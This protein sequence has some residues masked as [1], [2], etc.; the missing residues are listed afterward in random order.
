MGSVDEM[1]ELVEFS[2]RIRYNNN[3]QKA[4]YEI[5][6]KLPREQG[7]RNMADRAYQQVIDYLKQ[8]IIDKKYQLWDKLPSERELSE[9]LGVSRNSVREALKVLEIMGVVESH[10]GAGNYVADGFEKNLVETMSMMYALNKIDD[11]QVSDYRQALESRAYML[12]ME[13]I[14]DKDIAQMKHCIQMIQESQKD[15]EKAYWDKMFHYTMVRASG[16][17]MLIKNIEALN[18]I[19]DVFILNMRSSISRTEDGARLLQDAHCQMVEA[20][21]EKDMEKGMKAMDAHFL[22]IKNSL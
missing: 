12:A 15:E 19:I 13:Q 3:N 2:S 17:W 6:Q 8:G 22:Y 20:L 7:V 18:Q 10:Q 4:I 16:N 1:R 5:I 11:C 14:G 21:E 9:Q